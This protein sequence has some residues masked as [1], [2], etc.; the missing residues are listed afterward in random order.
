MFTRTG[1][2]FVCIC[3]R[4]MSQSDVNLHGGRWLFHHSHKEGKWFM[5]RSLAV[6]LHSSETDCCSVARGH[7]PRWRLGLEGSKEELFAAKAP[8]LADC[9]HGTTRRVSRRSS[10]RTPFPTESAR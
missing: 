1:A 5:E 7:G 4:C 3:R 6:A 9:K 10:I 8:L 2:E